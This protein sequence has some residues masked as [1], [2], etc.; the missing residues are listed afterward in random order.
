MYISNFFLHEKFQHTDVY[1]KKRKKSVLNNS[2]Y[3]KRNTQT[4][5]IIHF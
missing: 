5:G 1:V 2:N 3:Y 4:K